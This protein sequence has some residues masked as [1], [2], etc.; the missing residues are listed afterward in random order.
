[1]SRIAITARAGRNRPSLYQEITD[2]IIAELEAGCVPWVQP[3]GTAVVKA[4]KRC[5]LPRLL[6]CD[7]AMPANRHTF[8]D[9]IAI[10][11]GM[12]RDGT[13]KV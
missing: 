6:G 11:G 4:P 8:A 10:V 7:R 13:I 9:A 5:G 3:W 1:M 2:K 12:C